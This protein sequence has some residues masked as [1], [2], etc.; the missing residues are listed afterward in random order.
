ML[1][2]V[3]EPLAVASPFVLQRLL[4]VAVVGEE[5][6]AAVAVGL[7]AVVFVAVVVEPLVVDVAAPLREPKG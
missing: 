7:L 5:L 2:A 1:A 4:A 6:L 3:V